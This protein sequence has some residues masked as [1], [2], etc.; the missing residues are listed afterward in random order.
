M[1]VF[2]NII[3]LVGVSRF[4]EIYCERSFDILRAATWWHANNFNWY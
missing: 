1:L 4:Y 3:K 2:T